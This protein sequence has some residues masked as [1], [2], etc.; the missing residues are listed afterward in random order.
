VIVSHTHIILH[1]F[2]ITSKIQILFSSST[3]SHNILMWHAW[4]QSIY[5]QRL[6][7]KVISKPIVSIKKQSFLLSWLSRLLILYWYR[8]C[9]IM[10]TSSSCYRYQSR[11]ITHSLL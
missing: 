11:A 9:I 6:L 4:F 3:S 1:L 5:P 2:H 10:G 8:Q 7:K